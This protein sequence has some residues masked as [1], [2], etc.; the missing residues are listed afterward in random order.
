MIA[1]ADSLILV[2]SRPN[3]VMFCSLATADVHSMAASKYR[4]TIASS[5]AGG[6][7]IVATLLAQ[8]SSKAASRTSSRLSTTA[9]LRMPNESMPYRWRSRKS[10]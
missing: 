6:I 9:S 3:D 1:A 10:A 8:T 5:S 7:S 2:K 4:L